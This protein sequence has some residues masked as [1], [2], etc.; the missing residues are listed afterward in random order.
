MVQYSPVMDISPIT[1]RLYIGRKPRTRDDYEELHRLGIHF[2]INTIWG[3]KPVPDPLSP[4]I[5]TLWIG[6]HDFLFLPI[7]TEALWEGMQEVL[8]RIQQGE[9]ILVHCRRGRHRSVAMCAA[10]LIAQ[11][12]TATEAMALIKEK[13]HYANPY[14]WHIRGRIEKFE[15]EWKK[16]SSAI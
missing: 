12:M 16:R 1:D 3:S 15:R 10:I 9:K 13:R 6:L 8:P 5:P 14:A 4:P 7:P 2:I 11:G